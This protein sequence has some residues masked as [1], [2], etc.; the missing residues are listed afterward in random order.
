MVVN[1]DIDSIMKNVPRDVPSMADHV[2]NV[3]MFPVYL[4]VHYLL[5]TL[6]LRS[7]PGAKQFAK[8]HPFSSLFV[9]VTSCFGGAIIQSFVLGESLLKP[10]YNTRNV[11]LAAATWY[12]VMFSPFDV[13]EEFFSTKLCKGVLLVLKEVHRIRGIT[14]GVLIGMKLQS[15]NWLLPLILGCIRGS[16]A[17]FLMRPLDH[18]MRGEVMSGHE[19]LKPHFSTK[20]SVASSLFLLLQHDRY[21]K[22]SQP[23]MMLSL[24]ATAAAFQLG[25]LLADIRDP[26]EYVENVVCSVAIKAPEALSKKDAKHH[27]D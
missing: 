5:V 16:G 14:D 18:F 6:S 23:M 22:M 12:L 21:F 10:F 3:K 19:L 2:A 9:S 1:M 17:K 24:A 13:V 20:M 26:Y 15:G 4:T 25:M 7:R 27:K 8:D 11:S